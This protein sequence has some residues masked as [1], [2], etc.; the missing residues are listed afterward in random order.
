MPHADDSKAA[1]SC[2][3]KVFGIN[4]AHQCAI[5]RGTRKS[6]SLKNRPNV[7][8]CASVN[9]SGKA[10]FAPAGLLPTNVRALG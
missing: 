5:N 1:L 9:C 6:L 3:F 4:R 2:R 7:L 8:G 10:V